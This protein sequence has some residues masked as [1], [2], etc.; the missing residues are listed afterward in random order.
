MTLRLVDV[1][2]TYEGRTLL[3]RVNLGVARGE[4]VSILGPSGSGKTTL[5]RLVAGLERPDSGHV[6][7]DGIDVTGVPAHR[8]GVGLVFQDDQL[9]PHLDVAENVAYGL[10]VAGVARAER[11]AI[12]A[13]MLALVGLPDFG[14]RRVDRLSG[15]ESKRVAVA[16]ALAP[17]PAVLLLDEPLTGLDPELHDRLLDDLRAL[18]R[19]RATTVVHVT[20]DRT[21]A[22]SLADR[23]VDLRDLGA[24]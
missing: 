2:V 4:T 22:D 3:D 14:S 6:E 7:I 15:G 24:R 8:R 21:E 12:V 18:L 13:E 5:L 10:R 11:A 1:C 9:F 19:G 23:V 16:R 20:H 17:S